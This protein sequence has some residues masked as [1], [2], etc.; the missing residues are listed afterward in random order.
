MLSSMPDRCWEAAGVAGGAQEPAN[1]V[2][3]NRFRVRTCRTNR[4]TPA[5]NDGTRAP[6]PAG[7]TRKI[8]AA[9]KATPVPHRR[10]ACGDQAIERFVEEMPEI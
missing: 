7:D 1:A 2:G 10:A 9:S 3:R 4:P 5:A 8:P 6:A